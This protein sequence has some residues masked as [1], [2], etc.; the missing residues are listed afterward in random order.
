MAGA[1][2]DGRDGEADTVR[3]RVTS[4]CGTSDDELAAAKQH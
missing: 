2:V 1:V 4:G 3:L